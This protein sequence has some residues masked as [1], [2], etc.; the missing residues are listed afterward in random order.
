[1]GKKIGERFRRFLFWL[2]DKFKRWRE[3]L[4]RKGYP[5][6]KEAYPPEEVLPREKKWKLIFDNECWKAFSEFVQPTKH[7]L[8]ILTHSIHPK[9]MRQL[10]S[11]MN[12]GVKIKIIANRIGGKLKRKIEEVGERYGMNVEIYKCKNNHS[13]ICIRDKEAVILGSSNLTISSLGRP[14]R[15]G[16]LEGNIYTNDSDI[17]DQADAL[18]EAVYQRDKTLLTALKNE[19]FISSGY[20]IP[21]K[22]EELIE[23]AQRDVVIIS[24]PMI[25]D[26]VVFHIGKL[27][28][29]VKMTVIITWPD[30]INKK[31]YYG[32]E[33]LRHFSS[34][35]TGETTVLSVSED[36]HA[37]VFLIDGKTAVISSANLTWPSWQKMIEA[38]I[39]S[40]KE[41][42]VE[43]LK[44]KIAALTKR[45]IPQVRCYLTKKE[46]DGPIIDDVPI[47]EREIE[48][49]PDSNKINETFQN[50]SLMEEFNKLR[51]IVEEYLRESIKKTV[52]GE[53][54]EPEPL[55]EIEDV[56]STPAPIK[57]CEFSIKIKWDGREAINNVRIRASPD[58]PLKGCEIRIP[59]IQPGE[60]KLITL[61]VTSYD[62]PKES[63]YPIPLVCAYELKGQQR[64]VRL[65]KVSIKPWVEVKN[66]VRE[67]VIVTLPRHEGFKENIPPRSGKRLLDAFA[68]L[69]KNPEMSLDDIKKMLGVVED[70]HA[71]QFRLIAKERYCS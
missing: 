70:S 59:Q 61:P 28:E 53:V 22:L 37:K 18:F 40:E 13:K 58:P 25:Q 14:G 7:T 38:G 66:L 20:G 67:D 39:V 6:E 48:F 55:P 34:A 33:F 4:R 26:R 23:N 42:D 8:K 62:L 27:N 68:H 69:E 19:N 29:H 16:K 71:I 21:K 47:E 54:W 10:F 51:S 52:W 44:Q 41:E 43:F 57:K 30:K 15:D 5:P 35:R 11:Q 9:V 64:T 3:H 36:I 24:P 45:I 65:R 2:K 56:A 63:E 50:P 60:T 1:M 17:V 12:S 32:L 49:I 31:N 46:D